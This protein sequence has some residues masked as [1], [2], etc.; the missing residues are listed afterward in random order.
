MTW[1]KLCQE[2]KRQLINVDDGSDDTEDNDNDQN[3]TDNDDDDGE[4]SGH[5]DGH[6]DSDDND[7]GNHDDDDN[8]NFT[9]ERDEIINNYWMSFCDIQNNQGF[10]FG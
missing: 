9:F 10:G 3:G 1:C 5:S 2:K 8:G 4:D 6:D 7:G